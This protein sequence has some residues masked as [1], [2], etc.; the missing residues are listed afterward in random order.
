[1]WSLARRV[2]EEWDGLAA[3]GGEQRQ[4]GQ[5]RQARDERQVLPVG[6]RER[7]ETGAMGQEGYLGQEMVPCD[8]EGAQAAIDRGS[9][10]IEV[11]GGIVEDLGE[12]DASKR[13]RS[14]QRSDFV[15]ASRGSN[16]EAVEQLLLDR[17]LERLAQ[18]TQRQPVAVRQEG[19]D[20]RQQVEWKTRGS[21]HWGWEREREPRPAERS[22]REE[23][24]APS[25]G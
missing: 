2:R 3:N 14:C 1:M 22:W 12:R 17:P 16:L 21:F 13:A 9:G 6:Q 4:A 18:L 7:G 11:R 23:T 20:V 19:E 25:Q 10:A 8:S 24:K 5:T 15:W